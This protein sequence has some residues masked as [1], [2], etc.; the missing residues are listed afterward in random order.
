METS[1][2]QTVFGERI[3]ALAK[4][5][6]EHYAAAAKA[7]DVEVRTYQTSQGNMASFAMG[8]LLEMAIDLK[9]DYEA[10]VERMKAAQAEV[11]AK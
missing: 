11:Q 8:N 2:L 4:S 9:L 5:M 1:E 3:F 10:L 6:F 7:R